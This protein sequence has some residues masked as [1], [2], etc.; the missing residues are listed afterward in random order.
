VSR[1]PAVALALVTAAAVSAVPAHAATKPKPKPIKGSY[2]LTLLP[3]PSPNATNTLK[4]PGCGVLPQG[5]DKHPFTVP[6]AGKLHVVLDSPNPVPNNPAGGTD[7][8][9]YVVDADGIILDSSHGGTSH[10]ET[11]DPFK[12]RTPVTFWVCNLS[13]EPNGTVSYTFTYA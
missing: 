8:D 5:Q 12:K 10:E 1:R 4:K 13:G 6:A 7:W 9:L 3:D 2:T 11:T